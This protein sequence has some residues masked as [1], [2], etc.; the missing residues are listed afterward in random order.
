MIA[1]VL[2]E[3]YPLSPLQQGLLFHSLHASSPGEYI[4]QIHCT[5]SEPLNIPVLLDAWRHIIERHASLRTCFQWEGLDEPRQVV[6]RE[7][8]LPIEEQD[9][10]ALSTAEQETQLTDLLEADRQRSFDFSQAPLLRL[11]LVGRGEAAFFLLWT[12]HHILLDGQSHLVVLREV[13]DCYEAFCAGKPFTQSLSRPH[14]EWISW[15]KS[16]NTTGSEVFW[17]QYLKGFR[18]ATPLPNVAQAPNSPALPT[19]YGEQA[20]ELSVEQTRSLETIATSNGMTLETL[21]QGAWSLLLSRYSGEEDVVFGAIRA[22]R[23]SSFGDADDVVGMLINTLPVRVRL[24]PQ[25]PFLDVLRA[26]RTDTVAV[27]SHEQ[28]PLVKVMEWSEVPRGT[29]LFDSILVFDRASMGELLRAHNK[30]W[31]GR[32]VRLLQRTNYPLVLL[33]AGGKQ[34]S[35]R[36]LAQRPRFSDETLFQLLRN[37]RTLLEAVVA[38]PTQPVATVPLLTPEERHKIIYEWNDTKAPAPT[39]FCLHQMV[40]HQV[41]KTPDA[42][43]VLFE[44]QAFTY[45]QINERANR[46]AHYLRTLSFGPGTLVG[47]C[48]QRRVEMIVAVLGVLKSGAAY[49]PL[50][51]VYPPD[52]LAFMLED[53]KAPVVLTQRALR[54]RLPATEAKLLCLDEL[55]AELAVQSADNPTGSI[56][57]DSR[58][59]IIYTSGSTG[60]PKGVILRHAPAVNLIH[61]VNTTFKVGPGDRLLFVTSLSFDLSVYDVYGTLAAG[62]TLRIATEAELRDPE[63]LVRILKEEPITFWDSAPPMLQQLSPFFSLVP[64]PGPTRLRLVFLSGDWIPVPLPDHVRQTFAGAEVISLGGATEAA[65]WSNFFSIGE[66]EPHWPSIPYGKPI[67]NARYHVLDTSLQPVPVGIAAELHIGGPCLADGYLNRPELTAEKFIPDPFFPNESDAKL[68]KTGDLARYFPDGNLEFLGRID[69]QVKVRGYRI[70]LGEIETVLVQH[71]A[72]RESVVV[73][74]SDSSGQKVLVGYVVFRPGQQTSV[75]TLRQFMAAKLPEYMVPQHIVMLE[76]FVLSPN[77]KI[78]RKALPAPEQA[79]ESCQ[80]RIITARDE[81]EQMLVAIW[82]DVLKLN[83]ISVIDSFFDLGGHSLL[84]TQL[85]A[86]IKQLL[87]VSV[88]LASLFTSPTVE[89]LAKQIRQDVQIAPGYLVRLH[90]EGTKPPLFLIPGIGGHVYLFHKFAQRLGSDQPVYGLKAIGID[91]SERPPDRI[92]DI[93]ARYIQEVTAICPNGPL[94][95]GGYSL[96]AQIAFEMA[97]RLQQQ[98]RQ[99]DRLLVFDMFAPCYPRL[100]PLPRRVVIHVGNFLRLSLAEKQK[101]LEQRFANVK[102]KLLRR[103]KLGSYVAPTVTGMAAEEQAPLK[104]VWAALKIAQANYS[105]SQQYDGRILL[106]TAREGLSTQQWIGTINDD[107]L[108]GWRRWTTRDITVGE[109]PGEHLQMFQE[110]NLDAIAAAVS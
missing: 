86:K 30:A 96:G 35:L 25:L 31:E 100:L 60:R 54:D 15:L 50:D 76:K 78:D 33:A 57:S 10:S 23:R 67:Q 91:G 1:P 48:L 32:Q 108:L 87:G 83:P 22:C 52:R 61:R 106:V 56:S 74:R 4:Q 37:L 79:Q 34:L 75:E 17:R 88:P 58:A 41:A 45:R 46:L 65:I 55:D 66:V 39:Q 36:L 104:R 47:V 28:T 72:V 19:G 85:V 11:T 77:G 105:P 69:H 12:Y 44:G 92:E 71:P 107:P 62:S 84:A 27:R 24:T 53:T 2:C 3:S 20:I 9:W 29:A 42:V 109:C 95:L 99:V 102:E 8:R 110:R 98:G 68:Y 5:L 6:Q 97:V 40:E 103:L 26:L 81:T 70:E 16:Q 38:D 101:Y 13:F 64:A 7:V 90:P 14:S 18:A 80:R 93:A 21:V 82:E 59:Y 51:A 73:A 49:V 63:R 43:A 94:Q 89:K